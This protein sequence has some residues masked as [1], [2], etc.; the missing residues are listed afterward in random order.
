MYDKLIIASVSD[1][2]GF[3]WPDIPD[4]CNIIIH[5]GDGLPNSSRGIVEKEITFQTDWINKNISKYKKWSKGKP[6]FYTMGNHCY[7][8]PCPIL[9]DNGIECYDLTNKLVKY[10]N[11]TLYGFPYVP[12]IDQNTWNFTCYVDEM[13]IHIEVLKNILLN[14][15]VDILVAHCPIAN[16]LDIENYKHF[17][18][19]SMANMF[20]YDLDESYW[21]TLYCCGHCHA[22]GGKYAELK[23][24]RINNAATTLNVIEL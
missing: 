3:G 11:V 7:V 20:M 16:I 19:A 1:T 10:K 2:H 17:G 5:A 9:S 12:Y 15:K 13:Q 4:E 22:Q 23:N 18:N 6:I 8:N 21:P 24:M 14:N